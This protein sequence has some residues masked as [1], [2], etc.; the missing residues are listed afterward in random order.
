MFVLIELAVALAIL[1]PAFVI[2][3]K[4]FERR[5]ITKGEWDAQGPKHPTKESRYRGRALLGNGLAFDQMQGIVRREDRVQD[6]S[7]DG[8]PPP[9]GP[10]PPPP[11]D[12]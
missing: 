3:A 1:L 2:A 11:N 7:N 6:P 9:T 12:R 8:P 10:F 5:Q 4:R